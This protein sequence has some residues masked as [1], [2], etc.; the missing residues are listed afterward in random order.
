MSEHLPTP[1]NTY[2]DTNVQ[3]N[4]AIR[5]SSHH[6]RQESRS[7]NGGTIVSQWRPDA[8]IISSPLRITQ[9]AR[10]H[11]IGY[12]SDGM[13]SDQTPA[14][15]RNSHWRVFIELMQDEYL[16][17]SLLNAKKRQTTARKPP[18]PDHAV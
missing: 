6:V 7:L 4:N 8:E 13:P 12:A 18:T 1:T 10:T 17:N 2:R 9:F 11:L 14:S 3:I 5:A 16:L 15:R